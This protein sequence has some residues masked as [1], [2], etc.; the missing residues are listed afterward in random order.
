MQILCNRKDLELKPQQNGKLL[1]PKATYDL[2]SQEA[3]E[4]C[5]WLNVLRIP[6]GYASN[7]I[8]CVDANTRKLY[9][10][11][12]H[13][14]HVFMKRLLPIL[15]SSLPKHVLNQS[16]VFPI[17]PLER[18]MCIGWPKKTCNLHM[19]MSWLIVLKVNHILNKYIQ[20][21][22]LSLT[23]EYKTYYLQTYWGFLYRVFNTSYFH[24]T[25]EQVTTSHIHAYFLAWFKEQL[26][27][28]VAP[29]QEILH[30]RKFSKGP[31]QSENEWL[32]NFMNVY[33]FHT[34]TWT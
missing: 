5:R 24:T 18:R 10:M 17:A 33:K 1:K 25:S 9:R 7:L 19:F 21:T 28:I 14:C 29:T 12:S 11:K 2:T 32:T 34:Q 22:Y 16:S 15:L 30:L 26:S 23:F 6:N 4:V 8:R 27:C 31:V 13:E 3:K 20:T